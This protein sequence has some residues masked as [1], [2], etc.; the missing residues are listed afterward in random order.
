MIRLLPV[1]LLVLLA[2]CTNTKESDDVLI[3][4]CVVEFTVTTDGNT[5]DAVPVDCPNKS[6]V[7]YSVN[8]A[9]KFKYNPKIVDGTPQEVPGVRNR[10]VFE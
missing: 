7:E 6:L 2:A 3:N 8:A 9:L 4:Y 1:L 5:K 10:F